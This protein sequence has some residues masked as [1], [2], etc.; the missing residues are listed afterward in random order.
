[1]IER[2][3]DQGNPELVVY[4][5]AGRTE[6]E[7]RPGRAPRTVIRRPEPV[8]FRVTHPDGIAP[9]APE[10]FQMQE[11]SARVL[12]GRIIRPASPSRPARLRVVCA[13]PRGQPRPRNGLL[14]SNFGGVGQFTIQPTKAFTVFRGPPRT[15]PSR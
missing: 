9:R 14:K 2:V 8:H 6:T 11:F 5:T 13:D 10:Y 12:A 4:G 1:M 15:V 3:L 7:T